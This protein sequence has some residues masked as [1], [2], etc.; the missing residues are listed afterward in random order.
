[1]INLSMTHLWFPYWSL[2]LSKK[3]IQVCQ[4]SLGIT[5]FFIIITSLYSL[6]LLSMGQNAKQT[7]LQGR[8]I[9]LGS[10][11]YFSLR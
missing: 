11:V 1:M 3:S 9:D 5:L 10:C 7:Q 4:S 8:G 2:I 6:L